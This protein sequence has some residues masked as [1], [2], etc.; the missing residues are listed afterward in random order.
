MLTP[1]NKVCG[2]CTVQETAGAC[3]LQ[4][5]NQ[6]AHHADVSPVVEPLPQRHTMPAVAA[7]MGMTFVVSGCAHPSQWQWQSAAHHSPS[8]SFDSSVAR[9]SNCGKRSDS[10][11]V[12][13][14]IMARTQYRKR[15]CSNAR[16]TSIIAASRYFFT[17]RT[18]LTA[19]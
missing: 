18:I 8:G 6:E 15:G 16:L 7:C 3:E 10:V 17:F 14:N 12:K 19:Q 13:S 4:G 11:A 5:A 2:V 1:C 9:T